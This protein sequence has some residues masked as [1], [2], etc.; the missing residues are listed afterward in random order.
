MGFKWQ[1]NPK[2]NARLLQVWDKIVCLAKWCEDHK[3][4]QFLIEVL[5]KLLIWWLDRQL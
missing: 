1:K 3:I 2:N 5:I 4:P